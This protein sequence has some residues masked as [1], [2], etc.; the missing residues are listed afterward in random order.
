MKLWRNLIDQFKLTSGHNPQDEM[1]MWTDK[2]FQNFPAI[3]KR[4]EF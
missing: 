1:F 4:F 2:N 3:E